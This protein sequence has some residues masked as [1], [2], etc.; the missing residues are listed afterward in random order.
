MLLAQL[1]GAVSGGLDVVQIREPDLTGG[2][3]TRFVKD[4]V[5]L[6]RGTLTT[7]LVNDRADIVIA[8]GAHGLH[9]RDR[10]VSIEAA[11]GLLDRGCTIGRSIHTA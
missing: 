11:R 5:S 3:L 1:E 7:V 4:C 9:L 10:S 2:E 6:V 8:A